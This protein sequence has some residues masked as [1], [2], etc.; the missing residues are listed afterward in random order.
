MGSIFLW[1][2]SWHRSRQNFSRISPSPSLPWPETPPEPWPPLAT[3]SFF[4]PSFT[5]LCRRRRASTL[6]TSSSTW[7]MFSTRR[8]YGDVESTS[9]MN[10]C[11]GV[12]N[13]IPTRR[14]SICAFWNMSFVASEKGK[15]CGTT[16]EPAALVFV[17]PI[18]LRSIVRARSAS[19]PNPRYP[20]GSS[21][22]AISPRSTCSGHVSAECMSRAKPCA[23][24][25]EV[26]EFSVKDSNKASTLT[27]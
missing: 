9:A 19:T 1:A 20:F 26:I 25:M 8:T 2:A 10:R 14:L 17:R 24:R 21:A 6:S 11:S 16:S 27:D 7:N 4:C 15:S 12:T 5:A 23:R 3:A 18:L 22:C 13:D